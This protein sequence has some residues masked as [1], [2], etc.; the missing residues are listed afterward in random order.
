MIDPQMIQSNKD[1]NIGDTK[2][3][4][5]QCMNNTSYNNINEHQQMNN[6]NDSNN[7]VKQH[8]NNTS[9][10]IN[11]T[12]IFDYNNNND[13][14][15]NNTYDNNT[16]VKHNMNIIN[17]DNN[18]LIIIDQIDKLRNDIMNININLTQ[19]NALCNTLIKNYNS[20][21]NY[22]KHYNNKPYKQNNNKNKN[23]SFNAMKYLITSNSSDD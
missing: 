6:V 15:A 17:N 5:K 8:M 14:N 7:S 18:C 9:Y 23:K 13:T 21:N 19:I 16:N 20:V 11:N 12:N 1:T 4:D 3:S 2:T 22:I 10:V